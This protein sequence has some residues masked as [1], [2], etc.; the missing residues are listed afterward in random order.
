[1]D[2]DLRVF[3]LRRSLYAPPWRGCRDRSARSRSVS[4]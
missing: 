1:V 4:E 3:N 2:R